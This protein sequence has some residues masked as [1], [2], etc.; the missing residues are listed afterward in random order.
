MT[1]TA[2]GPICD[3][4]G[5]YILP[6]KA[7]LGLEPERIQYFSVASSGLLMCCDDH[8]EI[9]KRAGAENDPTVLPDGPLR[10]AYE[11]ALA[12]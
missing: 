7:L 4:G 9:L 6:I 2:C 1:L 11:K 12:V 5:E 10:R 8:L 3:V